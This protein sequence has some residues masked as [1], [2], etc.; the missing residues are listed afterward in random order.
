LKEVAIV[1]WSGGGD[2]GDLER[3]VSRK[4][5]LRKGEVRPLA[6]GLAVQ[7][8]D[9][10]DIARRLESMPG[11]S[12]IAVGYWFRGTGGYLKTLKALSPRY[13]RRGSR[14]RISV[15]APTAAAAGDL[16]L[17]GNSAILASVPGSRV[18]ERKPQVSFRGLL[19]GEEG[20]LGVEIRAGPG[21]VSTSGE[22]V[23]CMVSGG[24]N[25]S[26]MAWMAALS[27]F[28][29]SLVH[30]RTDD[31]SLTRVAKLYAELSH[32]MDPSGLELLVLGGGNGAS[33]RLGAWLAEAKVPVFAGLKSS[34]SMAVRLARKFP[35]LL[36]PLL[37]VPDSEMERVHRSL[38]LRGSAG[39][40]GVLEKLGRGGS[41]SV[42]R[43]EGKE[44][45][46]NEVIDAIKS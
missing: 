20:A 34:P 10:V 38:G 15:G 42:R 17:A 5:A 7:A 25:S 32:R 31:V 46:M 35:G 36:F 45:D 28:S 37:L 30:S 29:I 8:G 22:R 3:T 13:L 24:R 4:L 2:L 21:G 18:D 9:P 1:G 11:A 43:F 27:G 16:V 19:D 14:F 6:Q 40:D 23:A 26:G 33:G 44:A 41:Y 39:S 12:W